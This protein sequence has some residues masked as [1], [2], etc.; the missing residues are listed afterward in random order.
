LVGTVCHRYVGSLPRAAFWPTKPGAIRDTLD[1]VSVEGV[2]L[3]IFDVDEDVVVF[4]WPLPGR[5]RAVI[6]GPDDFVQETL[7]SEDGIEQD[8]AVVNFSIVDVEIEAAVRRQQTMGLGQSWLK[9]GQIIVEQVSK[10]LG[11]DL[12]R[13]N[14]D[15]KPVRS[16]VA[17]RAVLICVRRWDLPVLN[18]GI[19]IDEIDRKSGNAR[20]I[21]KLSPK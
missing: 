11:A 18:G 16:P 1:L 3:G 12:D 2:F 14:D 15:R 8:F 4:R 19:D 5:P 10:C 21:G 9:E 17:D 13:L 7:A 20:I 6:V